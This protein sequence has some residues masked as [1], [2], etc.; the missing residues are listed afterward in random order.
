MTAA[1]VDEHPAPGHLIHIGY[2][3]AG[4]TFL[5]EWF[6]AHPELAYVKGGFGGFSSIWDVARQG[7]RLQ[8]RVVYRVTSSEQLSVPSARAGIPGHR[9]DNWGFT[10][11]AQ[12]A[13]C[14]TLAGLFPNARI[15]LVTRGFRSVSLS[16]YSQYVRRGGSRDLES[17]MRDAVPDDLL[18]NYD[19]V[20]GLYETA[21][22]GRLIAMPYELLRDDPERFIAE[23][24]NEL[25]LSEPGPIP[26]RMN[27]SL[28][29]A[30][31]RW[32][33]RL[34]RLVEA[35]PLRGDSRRRLLDRWV[36][37]TQR[38]RMARP[39]AVLERLR[40]SPPIGPSNI[41]D[42]LLEPFRGRAETLR[43]RQLYERY[44]SEYL[45]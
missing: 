10:A 42:E 7:A 26:P 11:E 9:G 44:A 2:A 39:I 32:Y 17:L 16:G 19:R 41:S 21:F 3:K 18:W 30:E 15:L 28:S 23:L 33:P 13:V 24:Q 25:G 27:P 6:A 22:G 34:S 31:L 12:T 40:P 1:G 5:Q 20:V 8:R 37:W 36:G 29:A 35:V 14:S 4:S 38:N 43:G 45:L